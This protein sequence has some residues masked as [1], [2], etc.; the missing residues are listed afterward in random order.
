MVVWCVLF[1]GKGGVSC[2]QLSKPLHHQ[3]PPTLHLRPHCTARASRKGPYQPAA[4]VGGHR[5]RAC[6]A[7]AAIKMAWLMGYDRRRRGEQTQTSRSA[8]VLRPA[9][10]PLHRPS[11]HAVTFNPLPISLR[12]VGAAGVW[13]RV[14]R[15]RRFAPCRWVRTLTTKGRAIHVGHPHVVALHARPLGGDALAHAPIP[16][17]AACT[18]MLTIHIRKC[19]W[20]WNGGL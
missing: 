15:Q 9:P 16:N 8:C 14:S 18:G 11:V 12:G 1:E 13:A 4:M 5:A 17:G 6:D 20:A 19:C 2:Q 7:D 10:A 3:S